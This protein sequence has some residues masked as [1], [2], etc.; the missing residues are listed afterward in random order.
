VIYFRNELKTAHNE[1]G[2]RFELTDTFIVTV[3]KYGT[4]YIPEGFYTDYASV[5]RIFHNIISPVGKSRRA[6]VLHDFLYYA[7][8]FNNKPILRREADKL[9]YEALK[10]CKVNIFIAW[11]MYQAVK[12]CGFMAWNKYKKDRSM[13]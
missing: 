12:F 10:A 13:K 5:P 2:H 3:P 1:D 4:L 7:Q 11:N 9:F 8:T 6:A